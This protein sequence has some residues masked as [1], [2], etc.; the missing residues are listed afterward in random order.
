M[1]PRY[2]IPGYCH[3][4]TGQQLAAEWNSPYLGATTTCT[5]APPH[6]AAAVKM[7]IALI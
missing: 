4:V 7:V 5:T 6:T 2:R 1:M 3:P